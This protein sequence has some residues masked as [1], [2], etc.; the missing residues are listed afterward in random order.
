GAHERAVGALIDACRI[1]DLC[2]VHGPL[3]R[4]AVNGHQE[5]SQR[6]DQ[7]E[8]QTKAASRKSAAVR[9]RPTKKAPA[10]RTG[11]LTPPPA[12]PVA[13]KSSPPAAAKAPPRCAPTG[14]PAVKPP[15]P[16][17]PRASLAAEPA[18]PEDRIG[19]VTHYYSDL[20]VATLRLD[21]GMLHVGDV[22]HVRGHT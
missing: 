9:K 2:Y 13:G 16:A 3:G 15:I 21:S 14:S 22:I 6:Q 8:G 18:P 4:E 1:N 11:A 17:N 7:S 19:V 12:P 5:E 20:S 10:G